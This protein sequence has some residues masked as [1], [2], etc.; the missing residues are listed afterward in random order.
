MHPS[1]KPFGN[2]PST[3]RPLPE[4]KT[5]FISD[6]NFSCHFIY[7]TTMRIWTEEIKRI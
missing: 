1:F 2:T 3:D 6:I 5:C 7:T 4:A